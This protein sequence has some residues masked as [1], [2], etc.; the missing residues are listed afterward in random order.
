MFFFLS[1]TIGLL[2]SPSTLIFA[3]I[4]ISFLIK[5]EVLRKVTLF[6]ALGLLFFLSNQAIYS[7]FIKKW[8]YPIT[9]IAEIDGFD[10][11]IVLGGASRLD[12]SDTNRVFLNENAGDRIVQAVQLYKMRKIKKILYTSGSASLT[13]NKLAEADQAKKLFYILGVAKDDLILENQSR[14]T[15]ENALYSA[16]ILKR[17]YADMRY[18][19]ITNGLHMKRGMACFEKQAIECTPFPIENDG[20]YDEKEWDTYVIPKIYVMVGWERFFHEYVGFWS[21]KFKGFVS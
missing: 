1:K 4:A 13:G 15:Y 10:I 20:A 12:F 7:Y 11:A 9:P 8:A 18:L 2:A 6:F 21:Y 14:T 16:I 3:L 19:L 5:K 17:D